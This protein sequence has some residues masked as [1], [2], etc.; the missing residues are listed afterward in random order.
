M[1]FLK[2][3]LV[4][5]VLVIGIVWFLGSRLPHAH[6]AAAER[7]F[8]HPADLVYRAIATPAEY[9]KWRKGVQR[10][11]LL[12]DS[13]GIKRFR[14][15]AMGDDVVYAI[16]SS[17]PNRLFVTRIAQAGLPYGGSWTFEL[18]PTAT[19]TTV[20]ITEE[21]EVYNPFFRFISTYVMGH[22]RGIEG[23]LADLEARLARGES[24]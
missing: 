22:T 23:Y 16:E 20:R 13:N 12:P 19:G 21:G 24:L 1:R 5:L 15:T 6:V 17:V 4:A 7:A 14:E 3:L 9:P 2:F 18:T 8:A 10:V 11:E